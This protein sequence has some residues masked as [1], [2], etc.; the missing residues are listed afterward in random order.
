[1]TEAIVVM[2]TAVITILMALSYRSYKNNRKNATVL[3]LMIGAVIGIA[4]GL[5]GCMNYVVLAVV[6]LVLGAIN[7][8]M[9]GKL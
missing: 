3:L 8:I 2:V 4:V 6:P 5:Y 1:M 9:A 7:A